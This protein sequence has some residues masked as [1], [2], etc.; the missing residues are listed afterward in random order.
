MHTPVPLRQ[1]QNARLVAQLLVAPA[2][3]EIK[4]AHDDQHGRGRQ[5]QGKVETASVRL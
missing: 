2:R 1:K 3:Q 4:S 5:D